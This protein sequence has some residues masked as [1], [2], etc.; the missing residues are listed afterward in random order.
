MLHF[1]LVLFPSQRPAPLTQ[2]AFL[3]Q[4]KGEEA[5]ARSTVL[6]NVGS[7]QPSWNSDS[8]LGDCS[9]TF[10]DCAV[11]GYPTQMRHRGLCTREAKRAQ[12]SSWGEGGRGGGHRTSKESASTGAPEAPGELRCILGGS[13]QSPAGVPDSSCHCS[14]LEQGTLT[15]L[16]SVGKNNSSSGGGM[17]R[18]GQFHAERQGSPDSSL[19]LEN[20]TGSGGPG[21]CLF[22][23]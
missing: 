21:V 11:T 3:K 9:V 5:S 14:V 23:E 6:N 15:P 17:G 8:S 4:E 1:P 18:S 16:L 7:F 2:L 12:R 20:D 19:I 10:C 22:L 13:P